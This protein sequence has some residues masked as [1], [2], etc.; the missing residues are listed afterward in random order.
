MCAVFSDGFKEFRTKALAMWVSAP[1]KVIKCFV[2]F[3]AVSTHS[4]K[5]RLPA[6]FLGSHD[7]WEFIVHEF[8]QMVLVL[9]AVCPHGFKE[10]FPV[11][12][13]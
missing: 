12:V 8:R 13:L 10:P 11:D 9:S 6:T 3:C 7:G 1:K 2:V 4:G 5:P